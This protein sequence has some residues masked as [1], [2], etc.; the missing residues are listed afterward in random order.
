[1]GQKVIIGIVSKHDS[2]ERYQYR[3]PDTFI[4]DEVKQAILDNGG[5]VIGILPTEEEIRYC[6][7]KW[8]DHLSSREKENLI[9]Q[10]ELC[11]GIL[12][13][14]GLETDCYENIIAKYCYDKDIPILG[15]CA[16]QN[17]IARALGGTTYQI[18]NP[19]KH[20]KSFQEYVHAI[21]IE[22][23]SKFY[24]IV[25]T[26]EMLVNSRHKRAIKDCPL[27]RKVAFC[28][29]GYPDVIEASDKT[30]YMGVRF[31]P[32]SLYKKDKNMRKIFQ[33]FIQVCGK[34]KKNPCNL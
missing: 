12:L 20:D 33:Y 8:E 21:K 10:I 30:F 5:T 28:E 22:E 2:K 7:D 17:N 9:A 34:E 4:R 3:K 24:T 1:M 13:Q 16:G 18:P 15:I 14:G 29:D 23:D 6:G 27:L 25:K 19:E 11:D 31:H 26:T 32:E